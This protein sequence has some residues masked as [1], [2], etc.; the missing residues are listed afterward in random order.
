M[1]FNFLMSLLTKPVSF[2]FV[3]LAN[4]NTS[5]L[6]QRMHAFS[7]HEPNSLELVLD[8]KYTSHWLR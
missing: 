1:L 8:I 5:I 7:K 4:A 2:D 3:S 6:F